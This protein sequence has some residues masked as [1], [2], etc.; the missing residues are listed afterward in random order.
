MAVFIGAT[1]GKSRRKNGKIKI[2]YLDTNGY[3]V[4]S[5]VTPEELKLLVR[6]I[7]LTIE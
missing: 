3:K 4:Y 6:V 5:Y 2:S 7:D 1:K